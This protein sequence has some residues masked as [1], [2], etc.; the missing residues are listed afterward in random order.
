MKKS[1]L[2]ITVTGIWIGISEF[3]RNEFLFKSYW[4]E[5]YE[6]LGLTFETLPVN[7]VLWVAWSLFLAFLIY[8]LLQKFSFKETTLL[9]WLSAFVMM[10]ITG[11]NLQVLPV[12]L[13]IFAVPLSILEVLIAGWIIQ[14]LT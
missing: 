5:H 14:K 10:W 6:S 12:S 7:G 3:V 11:F 9:A 1:I 4:V 13:L 8:T 2:P